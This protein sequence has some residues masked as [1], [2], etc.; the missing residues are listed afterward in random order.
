[1]KNVMARLDAF[2]RM[3]DQTAL[4]EVLGGLFVLAGVLV[5]GYVLCALGHYSIAHECNLYGSCLK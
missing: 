3:E 2:N 1:M 4:H 5:V